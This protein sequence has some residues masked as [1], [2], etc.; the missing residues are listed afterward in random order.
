MEVLVGAD[1]SHV[2]DE[3]LSNINAVLGDDLSGLGFL[4]QWIKFSANCI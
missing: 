3:R 2:K 1:A 4:V